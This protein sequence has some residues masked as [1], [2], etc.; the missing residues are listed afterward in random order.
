MPAY[1]LRWSIFFSQEK[2]SFVVVDF[3]FVVF[4]LL[5][6]F[7]ASFCIPSSQLMLDESTMC[8]LI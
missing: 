4:S 8:L 1:A 7:F 2:G 5:F 3:G 6:F